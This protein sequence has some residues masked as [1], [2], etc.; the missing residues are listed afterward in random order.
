MET[1]RREY[2]E[3]DT[4]VGD[5]WHPLPDGRI[6]CDL[7]PRYCKLHEGQRAFCFVRQRRADRIVL[8]T[9]GK[10][11]GFCIDPIEKKPLAHFY[12]GSSVL[13]FGTAGCN[14]GCK[15]CQNWDISKAREVDRLSEAASPSA[16]AEAAVRAGCRSV[17]Y[18]YNDPVIFAEYA[19][20]TALACRERGVLN[21]AV[22]AGYIASEARKDFYSVID[23]ANVDLKAFTEEFYHKTCYGHLEEVLDT[24]AYLRNETQVWLEVTTLLIPGQNDS[25]AEVDQLCEWY[26]RTLGPDV[27]LHFT[28]FH[29]DHKMTDTPHT[30]PATLSRSRRQALKAGIHYVY[31]GNVLDAD[32]QSTYCPSCGQCVIERDWHQLGRWSMDEG[33]CSACGT[34]IAGRFGALP[35]NWGRRRTPVTFH[36]ATP[37]PRA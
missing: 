16:I 7:C 23:A 34:V 11:S 14:L 3:A 9:Y 28:A 25:E 21:V 31:T 22:T 37:G 2:I 6:Q 15:F 27:P 19:I 29:P 4:I 36:T 35:E 17:A 1:K 12:P 26:L 20:D 13:S 10:S 5:W 32:G 24:L 8:T 30:P 18:T 33:K